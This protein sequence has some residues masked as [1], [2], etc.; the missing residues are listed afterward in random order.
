MEQPKE[1]KGYNACKQAAC[2]NVTA[3]GYIND[4]TSAL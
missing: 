3:Y 4:S 1:N 2:N